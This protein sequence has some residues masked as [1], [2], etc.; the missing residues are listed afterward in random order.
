MLNS[1]FQTSGLARFLMECKRYVR[2]YCE[3]LVDR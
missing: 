3:I 2:E 1:I